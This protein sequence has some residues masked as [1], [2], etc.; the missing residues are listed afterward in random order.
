LKPP[1]R[2]REISL[3]ARAE[4]RLYAALL[5][6]LAG[7]CAG[8]ARQT[9]AAEIDLQKLVGARVN[10]ELQ[11]GRTL[12][13]VEL[14]E[15]KAGSIAG[16]VRSVTLRDPALGSRSA[17]GASGI[18]QIAGS[19]GV[20]LTYD[21]VSKSL[22]PPDPELLRRIHEAAKTA[23]AGGPGGPAGT[24]SRTP[25]SPR[26]KPGEA[27]EPKPEEKEKTPEE[28]EAERR[29]HFRKTGVWL[30]PEL[31]KEQQQAA[32][33]EQRQFLKKVAETFGPLQMRLYE[34]D[35]FLFLS[36]MPPP[37]VAL[38]TPYLDTMYRELCKA[39]AIPAGTNIWLG[40]GVVVAFVHQQPYQVFE[41]TFYQHDAGEAHGL[42]HQSSKGDVVIAC[43][44][45][46]DP[47]FFAGMLV[48]ETTHGFIH[49]YKSSERIPSWLNEGAA[50]WIAATVVASDKTVQIRQQQAIARLRQTGTLG[51]DFFT[52]EAIDGWQYGVASSMTDFLLRSNPKAYRKL[53]DGIK[54]GQSWEES[55]KEAFGVTPEGLAQRYGVCIGMP[56]LRP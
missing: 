41:R 35:Y 44:R 37:Q 40:K 55:L 11:S 48:H 7:A 56:G 28:K 3:A 52:A 50:D 31:T 53:F 16:T 13:D 23:D 25:R 5:A 38:Y 29:E 39:F 42:A 1:S 17:L 27:A 9:A 2:K 47:R 15:V 10:V 6:A 54:S 32:V 36:D 22:A 49:R 33:D 21:P 18:K 34:T 19:G 8:D 20:L 43:H 51:G 12:P 45:G 4:W 24:P 14:I 30:W 26:A 46:L